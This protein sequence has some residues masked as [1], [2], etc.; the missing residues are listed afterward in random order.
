V[1]HADG[2]I[3][4]C[5][6]RQHS[7]EPGATQSWS[8][9]ATI[10]CTVIH[11]LPSPLLAPRKTIRSYWIPGSYAP[12]WSEKRTSL[13]KAIEKERLP[14]GKGDSNWVVRHRHIHDPGIQQE[15]RR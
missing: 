15:P 14:G 13:L 2:A 12:P 9:S 3:F 4:P 11:S 6:A 7:K 10:W 1:R 5:V 8:T